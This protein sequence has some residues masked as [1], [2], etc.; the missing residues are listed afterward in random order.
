MSNTTA[1]E[2]DMSEGGTSE[3]ELVIFITLYSLVIFLVVVG[4][5]G[6]VAVILCS[7]KLRKNPSNNYLISLLV[8]RALIGG[9]VVPAKITILFDARYLGSVLCKLCHFCGSGSAVSSVFTIVAI[10]VNKYKLLDPNSADSRNPVGHSIKVIIV[11][12]VVGYVYAIKAAIT[13]DLVQMTVNGMEMWSCTSSPEF[14]LFLRVFLI[15]D[16]ICLFVIPFCIII[17]CYSRVIRYLKNKIK[18]NS[19]EAEPPEQ[20]SSLQNG[21]QSLEKQTGLAD[22]QK[23]D[24]EKIKE[25]QL[26]DKRDLN[27]IHMVVVLVVLFTICTVM[28]TTLQ[29][30]S[31]WGGSMFEG[32]NY[33]MHSVILFASSNPW[34]NLVI[35]LSFRDDLREGVKSLL[36]PKSQGKQVA[37][38]DA[39]GDTNNTTWDMNILCT[40]GIMM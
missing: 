27:T 16:I 24:T 14:S 4:N 32:F 36:K 6:M 20:Q 31:V 28:P 40:R 22:K 26:S 10:A 18:A 29:M 37:P 3:T 11:V 9:F 12:W 7:K 25:Q 35:F 34:I 17:V 13:N 8:S 2:P 1:T 19:T 33:L 39:Q 5:L 15:V 30:Y 38:F 23:N 21:D